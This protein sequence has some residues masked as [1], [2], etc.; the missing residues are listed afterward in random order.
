MR[1]LL[2]I[3]LPDS[4]LAKDVE[5]R[6]KGQR[7]DR[8]T[9]TTVIFWNSGNQIIRGSDI[10]ITDRLRIE[11]SDAAVIV[12]SSILTRTRTTNNFATNIDV[13]QPNRLWLTFDYLDPRDGVE[14][15]I[16]HTS[17]EL[18]PTVLGTIRGVPL[19]VLDWSPVRPEDLSPI[20]LVLA[21]ISP[22]VYAGINVIVGLMILSTNY[23]MGITSRLDVLMCFAGI[24]SIILGSG[25]FWLER[26]RFPKSLRRS[27]LK[28][29][30]NSEHV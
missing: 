14:I 11:V 27:H 2:L 22:R 15:E 28:G 26:R 19:G 12:D 18:F 6:F 17:S 4:L 29:T 20:P 24:F 3:G 23:H 21:Q 13:L 8:L 5:V 16:L 10:V 30:P 1:S 25:I 9:K 7:V